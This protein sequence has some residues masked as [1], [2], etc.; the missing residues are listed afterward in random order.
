MDYILGESP[1]GVTTAVAVPIVV[2]LG[3]ASPRLYGRVRDR[4]TRSGSSPRGV[5]RS[6]GALYS[7]D[8]FDDGYGGSAEV[9][10]EAEKRA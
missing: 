2:L 4:L 7:F 8:V 3:N 5:D 6:C 9:T 1:R 10:P